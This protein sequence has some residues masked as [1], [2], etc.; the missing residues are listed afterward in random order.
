MLDRIEAKTKE[1]EAKK[2]E[3][4][5]RKERIKRL[6]SQDNKDTPIGQGNY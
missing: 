1:N 4:E 2:L 6:L 3:N 5:K